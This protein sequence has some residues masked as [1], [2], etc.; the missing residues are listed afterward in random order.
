[1]LSLIT[2]A[3]LVPLSTLVVRV[4]LPTFAAL[5]NPETVPLS[6]GPTSFIVPVDTVLSVFLGYCC[7]ATGAEPPVLLVGVNPAHN[8]LVPPLVCILR[9]NPLK[10]VGAE[11]TNLPNIKLSSLIESFVWSVLPVSYTH[12][13]LPTKRIV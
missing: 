7:P 4:M 11:G 8:L 5:T 1:M 3:P 10:V 2:S 13:T 9:F 12:L 6:P